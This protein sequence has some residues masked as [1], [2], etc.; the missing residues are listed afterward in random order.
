M[1]KE[2]KV[3]IL[4]SRYGLMAEEIQAVRSLICEEFDWYKFFVLALNNKVIGLVYYNLKKHNL[5]CRMKPIL[6][7]LMK[8]YYYGN[9]E[10]NRCLMEE[11]KVLLDAMSKHDVKVLVLKGGVLLDKIYFDYGSRTCN[12]LDFFCSLND[13]DKIDRI[14]RQLKFIQGEYDWTNKR[15][16]DFSRIKKMGWKMNMNTIPTY[17]KKIEGNDFIDFLELDFSYAFDL[18]KDISISGTV[19][20]KSVGNEMSLYDSIIYLCAHLYKE[21]END[22]WIDAKADINLIKFCDI[23]E[24]CKELHDDDVCSLVCRSFELDCCAAVYYCAYYLYMIYGDKK[25]KDIMICFVK[26]DY[27]LKETKFSKLDFSEENKL[28]FMKRLFSYDNSQNLLDE[29]YKK[30]KLV[31]EQGRL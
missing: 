28:F 2:E 14:V 7:H 30:N 10:R 9:R 4:L 1:V 3:L 11:K 26:N 18:R 15:V 8:Y 5:M 17:I 29:T 24:T 25:F 20:E 16:N 27:E 21:A 31:I 22:I 23:R 6:M 19:F 13:I 12:D